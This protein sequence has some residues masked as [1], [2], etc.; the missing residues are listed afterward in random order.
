MVTNTQ[1]WVVTIGG[2]S[3]HITGKNYQQS[4]DSWSEAADLFRSKCD[5]LNIDEL[6]ELVEGEEY[7]T[8]MLGHDYVV[9]L[10]KAE[11]I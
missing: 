2:T 1:K 3:K 8:S 4:F 10:D 6:S 9:A 11:N 7:T 5:E